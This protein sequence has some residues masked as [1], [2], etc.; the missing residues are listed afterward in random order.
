MK[1]KVL[2]LEV[3]QVVLYLIDVE[4][5][6]TSILLHP[7]TVR[8]QLPALVALSETTFSIADPTRRNDSILQWHGRSRG[9][10]YR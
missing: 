9:G 3:G 6:G 4:E 8:S 1:F 5:K 10:Q 7:T 2:T